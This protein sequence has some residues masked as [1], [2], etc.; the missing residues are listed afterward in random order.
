MLSKN[1]CSPRVSEQRRWRNK[2]LNFQAL[3]VLIKFVTESKLSRQLM[4]CTSEA[5]FCAL[6]RVEQESEKFHNF[7]HWWNASFFLLYFTDLICLYWKIASYLETN[8]CLYLFCCSISP[9]DIMLTSIDNI[10][11]VSS[12]GFRLIITMDLCWILAGRQ[13]FRQHWK[14][15]IK[16]YKLLLYNL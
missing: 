15:M 8:Y 13:T 7:R 10:R 16:E 4:K 12:H 1:L 5:C 3:K 2:F 9:R 11:F 6:A 14:L